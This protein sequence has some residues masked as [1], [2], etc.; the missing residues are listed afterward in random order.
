MQDTP[1]D[2]TLANRSRQQ[3]LSNLRARA[4]GVVREPGMASLFS[5]EGS[6][7][8]P[9]NAWVNLAELQAKVDQRGR[10]NALLVHDTSG[11]ADEQS[12]DDLNRRLREVATLEDYGL[13]VTPGANNESVLNARGTY[14]P[15]PV[16][17][18]AEEAAAATKAPLR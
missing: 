17:K 5:L 11:K 4:T 3:A 15:V 9:R 12:R 18:A 8:V 2:A 1:R 13:S 14:I 6:Q 7:R 16:V 10:V